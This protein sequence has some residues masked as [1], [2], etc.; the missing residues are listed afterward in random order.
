[1]DSLS[2]LTLGA[3]VGEAVLGKKIGNKAIIWGAIAGTI[4]DLDI[5]FYPLLDDVGRLSFHRG[6]SHSMFFHL[7]LAPLLGWLFWK[8]YKREDISFRRWTA[9]FFLCLFTHSLL[10]CFTIY[11]TQLF[12]PFTDYPVA[13]N[14]IFVADPFYTFPFLLCVILT[15]FFSREHPKRQ[16]FNRLGLG[17]SCG[18][19]LFTFGNKLYMN[20]VFE[21]ALHDQQIEH[22]RYLTAPSPLNNILWYC[23]AEDEE[24]YH[25]GYHS[26]FDADKKVHFD[27]LPRQEELLEG[28]KD[29]YAINR[30]L[31]FANDYYIV[32]QEGE[33][34]VFYNVKFGKMGFEGEVKDF[35]FSFYIHDNGKGGHT[36][37]S[38]REVP[39]E[40][41]IEIFRTLIDRIS[42]K[43]AVVQAAIE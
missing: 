31:W 5:L 28:M 22:K 25:I 24:G 10:D 11:G 7:L 43:R 32:R 3:A 42:G 20:N 16:L 41:I 21:N 18:Y 35:V 34:L 9:F 40:P 13:L 15:M 36:F 19:L 2:Q 14:N 26:Y 17:L 8:W 33:Q 27:F 39:D 1:M 29:D 6:L 30:L 12:Q 4:P 23:V 38:E 37:T